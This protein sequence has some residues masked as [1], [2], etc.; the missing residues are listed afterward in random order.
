MSKSNA[1]KKKAG[2]PTSKPQAKSS[3]K[4]KPAAQAKKP[5][6][7]PAS[8]PAAKSSS[9][10]AASSAKKPA[11]PAASSKPAA[12]S[13][14][15]PAAPAP[16]PTPAAA[17]LAGAPGDRPKPKGITIVNNKPMRKPKPPKKAVEM[18]SLGAPLLGGNKK[19]KPLIPSGPNAKTEGPVFAEGSAEMP[20]SPF[21]KKELERYRDIL[22]KKRYELVGDVANLEGE[23][24][25]AS[26]GSLSHTPQHLAEQGTESFDQAL[27]LDI[28]QVDRNLIREIDDALKRIKDGTF[29]ICLLTHKPISKDRL[30]ELPWTRY[31]I[32]A[33]RERERREFIR[34]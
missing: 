12:A 31:S 9:K 8:K 29:G 19:W 6:A 34:P 24:L 5:A 2:K 16:A 18:P 28:A 17:P 32:E 23:A 20:K 1:A 22:L 25:N 3:S 27:S 14:K 21:N 7:K 30:E 15:K 4:S 11:A 33:A 13:A 10:P 26:S